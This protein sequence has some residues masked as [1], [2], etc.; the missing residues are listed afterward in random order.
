MHM[1]EPAVGPVVLKWI[2]ELFGL[3]QSPKTNEDV[4]VGKMQMLH[5]MQVWI[6]SSYKSFWK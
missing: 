1:G 4:Q 5:Q 6:E 3:E 2:E